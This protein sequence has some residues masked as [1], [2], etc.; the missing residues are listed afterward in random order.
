MAKIE[1]K[2]LDII[3]DQLKERGAK[4]G[5]TVNHMLNAGAKIVRLEMQAAMKEYK[6]KDTGDMMKSVKSSKIQK[7]GNGKS[8]SIAPQGV[9]RKGVP[10]AAKALVYQYGTS[11]RPARPWKTLAD[12]RAGDKV[13]QR[14]REV[15]EAE[16]IK[17]GGDAGEWEG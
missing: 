17:T 9:D 5:G 7:T 2:G 13:I 11:K 15:F 8:I 12:E 3:C 1:I 16:M 6:L 10:N 14:M 4:V